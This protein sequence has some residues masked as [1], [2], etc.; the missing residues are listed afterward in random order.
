MDLRKTESPISR[1]RREKSSGLKITYS[2]NTTLKVNLQQIE[3]EFNSIY[4]CSTLEFR[5]SRVMESEILGIREF[6]GRSNGQNYFRR[7][8]RT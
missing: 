4:R 5:R 8:A 1:K 7:G 2:Q 3:S 6:E